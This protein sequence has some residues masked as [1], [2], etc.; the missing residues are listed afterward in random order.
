MSLFDSLARTLNDLERA[1]ASYAIVGGLA[2]GIRTEPRFTRDAD[3]AVSVGDDAEAET[4]VLGLVSQG[5]KTVAS[6]EQ[7]KTGRLATVRLVPPLQNDA[8]VI[9]DLLFA[10]CGIEPEIVLGATFETIARDV[11]GP[12]ASIGHLIAMKTLSESDIR[13]QDRQDLLYLIRFSSEADLDTART[14]INLIGERGF[15]RDK[16]LGAV[17]LEYITLAEKSDQIPPMGRL[18]PDRFQNLP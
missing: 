13:L 1:Y 11:T 16:D 14:G 2:V 8:G 10:S 17:L 18:N 5:Y 12:V 3:V 7:E 9:V 4:L 6:L 15:A